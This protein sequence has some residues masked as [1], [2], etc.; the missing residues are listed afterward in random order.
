[1]WQT[2]ARDRFWQVHLDSWYENNIKNRSFESSLSD[3]LFCNDR[4]VY[5]GTGTGTTNTYY[6][7][8]NRIK[9]T[10][11]P[12]LKC[13]QKND[14]FTVSDSTNGNANLI[15]PIGLIN[16]DE[17]MCFG[18]IYNSLSF[19]TD[20]YSMSPMNFISNSA[21]IVAISGNYLSEGPVADNEEV[22]PVIN[23]SNDAIQTMT[24]SGTSSDPF[25][26]H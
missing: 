4:S 25:V 7:T 18:K 15:Y 3:T 5:S 16:S 12:T 9:N 17:L 6:D 22:K 24:G 11:I 23:I 1:M 26:V 2:V 8:Y 21:I 13:S 20:Y 19:T 14:R 10:H